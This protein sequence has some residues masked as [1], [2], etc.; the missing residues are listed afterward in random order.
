[1]NFAILRYN[2][3]LEWFNNN[4]YDKESDKEKIVFYFNNILSEYNYWLHN[5]LY[6]ML[7]DLITSVKSEDII[8]QKF[9]SEIMEILKEE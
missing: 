4:T 9:Y 1:L 7:I 8:D 5:R 3:A 6:F 2:T